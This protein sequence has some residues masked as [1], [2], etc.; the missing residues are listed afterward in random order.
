MGY[1]KLTVPR[2]APAMWVKSYQNA[3]EPL[4]RV[5]RDCDDVHLALDG[6]VADKLPKEF[7]PGQETHLGSTASSRRV[8]ALGDV[9][10][11]YLKRRRR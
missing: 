4:A 2:I 5:G 10:C 7:L 9:Q 6:A 1:P 3:S 11:S 8:T